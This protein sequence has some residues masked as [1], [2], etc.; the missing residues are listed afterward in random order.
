MKKIAIIGPP[1]AGKTTLARNLGSLLKMK[2]FHLDRFF[3]EPGRKGKSREERLEI[4][5][6]LVQEKQWIIEGT[7]L[8]SSEPRLNA[9]DTI[10]FLDTP[11]LVCLWRIVK[12][13]FVYFGRPRRDIPRGCTDRLTPFRMLRVVIFRFRGRKKL[14]E[15]LR[16]FPRGKVIRLHSPKQVKYYLAQLELHTEE[17]QQSSPSVVKERPLTLISGFVNRGVQFCFLACSI[18]AATLLMSLF[19]QFPKLTVKPSKSG[20]NVG[21]SENN[22]KQLAGI[23]SQGH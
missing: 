9:A 21:T 20:E 5:D 16:E 15:R 12:R 17:K 11:P 19:A 3:W 4:L 2:I 10:I 1:G 14:K 18:G 8:D 23:A 6:H 7:Y 22:D 13:Y